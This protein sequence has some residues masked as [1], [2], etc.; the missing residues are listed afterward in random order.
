MSL[1]SSGRARAQTAPAYR[2]VP[3]TPSDTGDLPDGA[4]R[5]LYV[6]RGGDLE[7]MDTAGG[8][9][10]LA[11][12]D[13]QYHPVCVRRVLAGATTAGGIVALY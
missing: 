13:C 9:V 7:V 4:S 11:S 2:L 6:T 3:V 1:D 12:L 5:G 10:V 8:I